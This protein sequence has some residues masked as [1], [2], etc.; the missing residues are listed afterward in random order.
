ML[1][2]RFSSEMQMHI[3]NSVEHVL[4]VPTCLNIGKPFF[5]WNDVA[6]NGCN[7]IGF[8]VFVGFSSF[9]T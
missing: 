9:Y 7:L 1:L 5:F 3:E 2:K 4:F 8:C 6:R